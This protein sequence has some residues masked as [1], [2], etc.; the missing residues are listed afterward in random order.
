MPSFATLEG[1]EVRRM[2][3][4][5]DKK[6]DEET[7]SVEP[8]VVA[9]NLHIEY[10]K[11]VAVDNLNLKIHPGEVVGLLGGNGAGKSSTLRALAGVNPP[12]SGTLYVDGNDMSNPLQ[13]EQS[14]WVIGYCPDVGGLIRQATVREHIGVALASRDRLDNWAYALDLVKEFDLEDVLDRETHGFSHGMSRRL[15]VLLAALTASSVL[16]LDEPFD[17]VDPT[18]VHATEQ[19]IIRARQ[20]GIAT[21]VSTHLL[22]LLA[23]VSDRIDVML[24]GT[25]IESGPA[26]AYKNGRGAEHYEDLLVGSSRFGIDKNTKVESLPKSGEN[27]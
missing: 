7:M 22:S 12:T 23:G 13:A 10:G 16:I 20:A 1:M 27:L 15:S 6:A 18:G 2:T 17:G 11:V 14:R 9:E 24:R 5:G 21:I 19:V 4:L 8:L 25:I 3:I 26:A